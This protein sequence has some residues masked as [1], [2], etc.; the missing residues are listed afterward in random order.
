MMRRGTG[1]RQFC[2]SVLVALIAAAF[3][4]TEHQPVTALN[5][6]ADSAAQFQLRG[7]VI[8]PRV[9]FGHMAPSF[10]VLGAQKSGT[11]A[12]W[13][14]ITQHPQIEKP[15]Q[16]ETLFFNNDC[17]QLFCSKPGNI[18]QGEDYDKK[19]VCG[20]IGPRSTQ[21]EKYMNFFVKSSATKTGGQLTGE[22]SATYLGCSCCV[23]TI[24]DL[25]PRARLIALLRDPVERARSR[26]KEQQKLVYRYWAD[27]FDDFSDYVEKRLPVMEKCLAAAGGDFTKLS[28]CAMDDNVIGWSMYNVQLRNWM[29]RYKLSSFL[30]ILTEDLKAVPDHV[31]QQVVTHLGLRPYTFANLHARYNAAD[32]GYGWNAGCEKHD[33]A[34]AA[35][36]KKAAKVLSPREAAAEKKLAAFFQKHTMPELRRLLPNHDLSHWRTTTAKAIGI[37]HEL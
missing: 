8:A 25:F 9:L 28:L 27:G 22:S 5:D 20:K 37:G 3:G 13:N 17:H 34:K 14:L 19:Q 10:F 24:Y 16:K 18:A 30:V 26:F 11:S 36:N 32:C 4:F 2:A 15:T 1:L 35:H 29:R 7:S 6:V 23:D 12:L 33:K 21:L 31:M